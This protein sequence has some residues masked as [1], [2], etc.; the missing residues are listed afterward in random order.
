MPQ[1]ILVLGAIGYIGQHL[2]TALSQQGHGAGSGTQHGTPA[3]LHLPGV[4]C[5]NVDLNWPKAL[6]ALLEGSIR[7]TTLSTAWAK[8]AIL[9]PTSVRWR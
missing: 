9:S 5:H 7:F 8:A 1:R 3:K 6:P 4:T 2:T